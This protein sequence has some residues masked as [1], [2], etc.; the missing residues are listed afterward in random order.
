MG[1]TIDGGYDN[2]RVTVNYGAVVP[3]KLY[4]VNR[5]NSL[6][7][8][9][10]PATGAT[11]AS[12]GIT[13]AGRNV[14]GATGMAV[15]PISGKMYAL[16]RLNPFVQESPSVRQLVT[17]DPNTGMATDIGPANNGTSLAFSDLAFAANGTLYGVTGNS[18]ASPETMFT[19]NKATGAATFFKTLGNG[20]DG[21]TIAYNPAD[22]LMYHTSGENEPRSNP[23]PNIVFETINLAEPTRPVTS[24]TL[25]GA[26]IDEATALVY[27]PGEFFLWAD[28]N[29]EL[30]AGRLL[31]VTKTGSATLLGLLDHSATGL[32]FFPPISQPVS[33]APIVSEGGVVNNGSYAASPA[34][35]APGSIAAVFGSNLNNGSTV[36]WAGRQAGNQPGRRQRNHQWHSRAAILFHAGATRYSDSLRDGGADFG[37]DS[38]DGWRA[39]QRAAHHLPRRPRAGHLHYQQSGNRGGSHPAWRWRHACNGAEPGQA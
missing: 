30:P 4:S 34:P 12:R 36:L 21:E 28:L 27:S 22:G 6:L 38:G 17:V 18:G 15:D 19:L 37:G 14:T 33:N 8:E 32:A 13:L 24:L 16:L 20:N 7:R 25:S 2:F 11:L 35:V 31:R 39:D 29:F 5:D 10:N 9:I 3:P 1:F 23:A 26:T